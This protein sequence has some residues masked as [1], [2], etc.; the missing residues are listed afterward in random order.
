VKDLDVY[1]RRAIA[2]KMPLSDPRAFNL[3]TTLLNDPNEPVHDLAASALLAI[4]VKDQRLIDP[5][6]TLL[7]HRND[8]V[9]LKA[10]DALIDI[11]KP[12]VESLLDKLKDADPVL[13][14]N[15]ARVLGSIRD[16][17]AIDPLIEL[18][19]DPEPDPRSYAA[20]S[21]GEMKARR[22]V[23]PL[24]EVLKGDKSLS[25][26]SSAAVALIE[27]GDPRA[28]EPI[29]A[30][31]EYLS[32]YTRR[33]F[34]EKP[35]AQDAR[36]I[37]L[38]IKQL[39]DPVDYIQGNAA[40]TLLE[41]G[42]AR[43]FDA[44]IAAFRDPNFRGRGSAASVLIHGHG[45]RGIKEVMALFDQGN[46]KMIIEIHA[47]LIRLGRPETEDGLIRALESYGDKSAAENFINCGNR[48]LEQAGWRWAANHG[49]RILRSVPG[50]GGLKW[51]G[52]R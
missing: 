6:I 5:L 24:I 13:R 19:K 27:I 16:P 42:D 47:S 40:A 22:A 18:L 37:D 20:D 49:Y 43:A 45:D 15:A 31:L 46:L 21:L 51:G 44:V 48:K 50:G 33:R 29:M 26:R 10:M 7:K 52:L 1:A 36:T 17:R 11:G 39:K 23:V 4:K 38:L 2:E 3:L 35:F 30:R 41:S 12:A 34:A 28:A 9:L 32:D 25:V 14:T 8:N